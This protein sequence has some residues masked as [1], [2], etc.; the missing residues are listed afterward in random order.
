M[1]AFDESSEN[2][3][4]LCSTF[5]QYAYVTCASV[6]P[7]CAACSDQDTVPRSHGVM[8]AVCSIMKW[9]QKYLTA[10]DLRG[11]CKKGIDFSIYLQYTESDPKTTA[12]LYTRFTSCTARRT[13][14]R[15]GRNPGAQVNHLS[16]VECTC[17][18]VS[19]RDARP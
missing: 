2:V 17:K 8:L 12:G 4:F 15:K 6:H 13:K 7:L 10:T 5:Q 16:R 14:I 9:R 3:F 19:S 1:R 11:S 18:H